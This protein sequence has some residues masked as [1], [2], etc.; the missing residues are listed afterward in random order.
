MKLLLDMNVSP[1]LG[2]RLER[3]G[4]D[5]V[6]WVTV[7]D[8]RA[9]DAE[10]MSHARAQGRVVVTHDLDFGA[11]LALTRSTGP[12]VVQLRVQDVLSEP[13]E[14]TLADVLSVHED[15]LTAGALIV[16]DPRRLRVRVLPLAG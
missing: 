9:P 13:F 5:V 8:P 10:V 4:H 11:A 7:G 3:R 14:R 16:V 12:S 6:H 15:A 1:S 2:E